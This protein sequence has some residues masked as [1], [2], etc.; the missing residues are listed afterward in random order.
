MLDVGATSMGTDRELDTVACELTTESD[1]VD[2][3]GVLVQEI[4]LFE[5]QSLGLKM[6]Y[7]LPNNHQ[8]E[9]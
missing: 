1:R 4:D 5:G 2:R 6:G 8:G 7:K 9:K 3:G